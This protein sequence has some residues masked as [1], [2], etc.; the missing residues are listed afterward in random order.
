MSIENNPV[1][2][3][4]RVG[5]KW[6]KYKVV[7]NEE[8]NYYKMYPLNSILTFSQLKDILKTIGGK[9]DVVGLSKDRSGLFLV[10]SDVNHP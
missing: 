6:K 10:L 8:G 3:L 9:Y 4:E 5:V 2:A 7:K 1:V